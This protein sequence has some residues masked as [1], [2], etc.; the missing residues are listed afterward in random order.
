M[1]TLKS[2]PVGDRVKNFSLLRRYPETSAELEE[3]NSSENGVKADGLGGLLRLALK[4]LNLLL[5][6]VGVDV[7]NW[8]SVKRIG[9]ELLQEILN[10]EVDLSEHHFRSAFWQGEVSDVFSKFRGSHVTHYDSAKGTDLL[11]SPNEARFM[12]PFVGLLLE[13]E[14]LARDRCDVEVKEG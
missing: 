12:N 9:F 1:V 10:H 2:S 5:E 14:D 13:T 7:G 4:L 3:R 6:L 8:G 11:I